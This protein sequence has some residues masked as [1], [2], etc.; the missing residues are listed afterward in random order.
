MKTVDLT[1]PVIKG[2]LTKLSKKDNSDLAIKIINLQENVKHLEEKLC[3]NNITI[4]NSFKEVDELIDEKNSLIKQVN[5]LKQTIKQY[6]KDDKLKSDTI[7]IL[8][9]IAAILLLLIVF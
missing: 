5:E 8:A 3:K 7:I 2:K 6:T 4:N 9:V 1:N